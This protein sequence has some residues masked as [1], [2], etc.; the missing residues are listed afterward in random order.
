MRFV[1]RQARLEKRTYEAIDELEDIF[2]VEVPSYPEVR[3]LGRKG[4]V[5]D[6]GLHDDFM[7]DIEGYR[8][9][10]W[11]VFLHEPNMIIL[12]SEDTNVLLEESTHF[13]HWHTSHINLSGRDSDDWLS[14][15]MLM[16]MFGFLGSKIINFDRVNPFA[17]YPDYYSITKRHGSDGVKQ[18]FQLLD[19]EQIAEILVH[20]QGYSLGERVFYGLHSGQVERSYLNKLIRNPFKRKGEATYEFEELRRKV[21]PIR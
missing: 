9:A 12:N 15:N 6:L 21:W 16:E 13:V 7:D 17:K 11:S 5:E 2:N 18:Y 3:W 10:G 14:V 1:E 4:H 8:K 19:S 20:A